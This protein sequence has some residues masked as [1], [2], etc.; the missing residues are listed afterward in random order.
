M[1]NDECKSYLWYENVNTNELY[2][3]IKTYGRINVHSISLA[4][5]RHV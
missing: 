5:S 1:T 4:M 2:E 3:E